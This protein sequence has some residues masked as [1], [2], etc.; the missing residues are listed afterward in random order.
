MSNRRTTRIDLRVS[1]QEKQNLISIAKEN[2]KSLSEY[3][4]DIP[5][6]TAK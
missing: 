3:I 6:L 4:R 5:T 1:E 2:G